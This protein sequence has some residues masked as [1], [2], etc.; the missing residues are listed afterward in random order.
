VAVLLHGGFW[1]ARFGLGLMEGLAADLVARGWVAWNVEHR[2]LGLLGRGGYPETVEDAGH[3]VDALIDAEA[4]V[5]LERV[6]V[7][8]HSSGGQLA[9]RAAARSRRRGA[10]VRVAGAVSLAGVTDLEAAAQLGL[11]DGIVPR[12]LG[13]SPAARPDAY[14]DASPAALLPLG[15]PQ[16][17]VHGDADAVVP[18]GMSERYAAAARAGGDD[19]R[20]V[21]REGEGH[22]DVLDP[23]GG[24]WAAVLAWLERLAA[25]PSRDDHP[26]G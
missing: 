8:G 6:V 7:I 11:G 24:A 26:P 18:V 9:L 2:R 12:F 23:H 21:V 5:D 19:V 20:L 15:L 13:G 22:F 16:L 14:R 3:A 25:R 4:P 10:A 1:R 17:V